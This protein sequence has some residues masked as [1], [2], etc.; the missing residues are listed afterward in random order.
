MILLSCKITNQL[1]LD[2]IKQIKGKNKDFK[3]K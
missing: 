2:Y 3:L 1:I